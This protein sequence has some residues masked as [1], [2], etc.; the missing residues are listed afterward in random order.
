M[1]VDTSM[2]FGDT[3]EAW[4]EVGRCIAPAYPA[5][6][7]GI[8]AGTG[9]PFEDMRSALNDAGQGAYIDRRSDP[10]DIRH[11]LRGM[12]KFP[13]RFRWRWYTDFVKQLPGFEPGVGTP[14]LLEEI[15]ERCFGM[16]HALLSLELDGC[17]YGLTAIN[18]ARLDLLLGLTARAGK[19]FRVVRKGCWTR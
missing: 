2:G 16:G 5:V 7:Q 3:R 1:A 8:L 12:R 14:V 11:N 4:A 15:G 17:G 13:Y 9:D 10:L 18:T 6:V 19:E